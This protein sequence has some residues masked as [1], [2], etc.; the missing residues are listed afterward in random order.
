[1]L[2]KISAVIISALLVFSLCG[3]DLLNRLTPQNIPEGMNFDPTD[4]E[5]Y[6]LDVVG[7]MGEGESL[8]ML[9]ERKEPEEVS[10]AANDLLNKILENED[11]LKPAD[12]GKYI[13]VSNDGDDA[14][15]GLTPETAVANILKA[16]SLAKSGD[17][18]LLNRGDFWRTTI[19]GKEG[20][21]YGAYGKGNKPTIYGSIDG[22]K[23]EWVE[24]EDE[25]NVWVVDVGVSSDIGLIVFDNGKAFGNRKSKEAEVNKN[26]N[27]YYKKR[28]TELYFYYD[29]GNPREVFENIE[30]CPYNTIL[31]VKSNSTVQNLRLM[32]TGGYGI[33]AH[34]GISNTKIQ[35]CVLGYMGGG[36]KPDGGTTRFGNGIELW[37][38]G[39]GFYVD[40][41]HIYQ[42]YDAGITFQWNNQEGTGDVSQENIAFTNNLLEYSVYNVEYFLRNSTGAL[43]NIE[44]SNNIMRYAGYGWGRLSRPDKTSPANIKGGATA[45]VE[46]YVIKNNVFVH[47]NPSLIGITNGSKA[48]DAV[49]SGNTYVVN[50]SNSLYTIKYGSKETDFKASNSSGKTAEEIFGDKT[51]KIIIY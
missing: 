25:E 17:V 51:G 22:K 7:T 50:K 1:M 10:K 41:C 30:I 46:N 5:V 31:A 32:Y 12:D 27:F 14:N 42:I 44:I 47:G 13:Y 9:E 18:I 40:L 4:P 19:E 34:G 23:L 21:S 26:F 39:N 24:S 35:G 3:C 49:F 38:R 36:C 43:R 28:G 20:V 48:N 8:G 37:G 33:W 45:T 29:G 16:N 2:K 6:T 15:D 11:T